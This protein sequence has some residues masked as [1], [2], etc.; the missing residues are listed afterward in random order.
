MY[1]MFTVCS[2]SFKIPQ[3]IKQLNLN[4]LVNWMKHY[5]FLPVLSTEITTFFIGY[6]LGI[7][8][9]SSTQYLNYFVLF[10][11]YLYITVYIFTFHKHV[12][13]HELG[14]SFFPFR[15]LDPVLTNLFLVIIHYPQ[16]NFFVITR[17]QHKSFSI[18]ESCHLKICRV[19][20]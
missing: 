13:T 16:K 3:K 14:H 11:Q 5:F 4:W 6:I 8:N 20:S 17:L 12:C 1:L 15:G 18:I 10:Q 19:D 7:Q 2:D 9:L